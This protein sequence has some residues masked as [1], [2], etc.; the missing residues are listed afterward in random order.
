MGLEDLSR[1]E[2]AS[3]VS[4]ALSLLNKSTRLSAERF[5]PFLN[6]SDDPGNFEDILLLAFRLRELQD[7]EASI[8]RLN[9]RFFPIGK[10]KYIHTAE[11]DQLGMSLAL[12]YI[13]NQWIAS[14]REDPTQYSNTLSFEALCTKWLETHGNHYAFITDEKIPQVRVALPST[15]VKALGEGLF[16]VPRLFQEEIRSIFDACYELN[17]NLPDLESF[18]ITPELSLF[19]TLIISRIFRFIF[20]ARFQRLLELRNTNLVCLWNSSLVG[21]KVSTLREF[22]HIAG[23]PLNQATAYI[24]LFTWN[25]EDT[26]QFVDLQYRSFINLGGM[27]AVPLAIHTSSNLFRNALIAEGKRIYSDGTYDPISH[28][29]ETALKART[30]YTASAVKYRHQTKEGDIDVLGVLD[31]SLYIFE[32]KNTLL[33]TSTN[34]QQTTHD[35]IQKA[36]KQLERFLELW[37][38]KG[39]RSHISQQSNL[40]LSNI[41]TV[42]TA[43]V[44]SN[45]LF[46][47]TTIEDHPVRHHRELINILKDGKTTAWSPDGKKQE[48]NLWAGES[49]SKADLDDYLSGTSKIYSQLWASFDIQDR[50]LSFLDMTVVKRDFVLNQKKYLHE[51]GYTPGT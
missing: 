28:L 25:P 1:E 24:S 32:C 43:I 44:L 41:S 35:H 50:S 39:F 26:N 27:L 21:I 14:L 15:D 12:G 29:L 48:I 10:N 3:A 38:D 13:K 16:R 31:N 23:V 2:S 11:T 49:F 45:R 22:L 36:T 40:D 51:T 47:G 30:P 19:D 33:P 34:E 5:L 9:Y 8:F 7:M 4:F 17:T 18:K 42:K 20:I 46:S 6:T 37:N